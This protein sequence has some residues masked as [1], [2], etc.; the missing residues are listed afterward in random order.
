M[1]FVAFEAVIGMVCPLTLWEDALCSGRAREGGFIER[2]V[3]SFRTLARTH[4]PQSRSAFRS[5]LLH[6]PR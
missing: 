3:G 4:P 5:S 2:W 1:G 6:S